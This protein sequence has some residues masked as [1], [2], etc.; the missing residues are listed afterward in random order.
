MRH[1]SRKEDVAYSLFGIFGINMPLLYGEGETRAFRRLQKEIIASSTDESIFCWTHPDMRFGISADMLAPSVSYFANSAGLFPIELS[2]AQLRTH[3]EV[4]SRGVRINMVMALTDRPSNGHRLVIPLNCFNPCLQN[5]QL[6][7]YAI[8][9]EVT[10]SALLTEK[11]AMI[12]G[13]RVGE[14]LIGG[15]NPEYWEPTYSV[16]PQIWRSTQDYSVKTDSMRI[17]EM[18]TVVKPGDMYPRGAV[19]CQIYIET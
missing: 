1:A 2:T 11:A 4:T 7:H 18:R 13:R 16:P 12:E 10:N 19:D 5:R 14:L 3:N 15:N 17:A 6:S 9:I 8:V